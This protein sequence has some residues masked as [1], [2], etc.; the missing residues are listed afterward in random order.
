[1]VATENFFISDNKK[2]ITIKFS[3]KKRGSAESELFAQCLEK[4]NLEKG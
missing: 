2:L 1:M 4:L 3:L